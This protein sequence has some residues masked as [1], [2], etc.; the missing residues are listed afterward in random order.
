MKDMEQGNA[1]PLGVV[2]DELAAAFV[3]WEAAD[4]MAV[5]AASDIP[6]LTG[7]L[8]RIVGRGRLSGEVVIRY[9]E[10]RIAKGYPEASPATVQPTQP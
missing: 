6:E 10:A 9:V 8:A 5:G 4:A 7:A 3:A 1:A 2:T